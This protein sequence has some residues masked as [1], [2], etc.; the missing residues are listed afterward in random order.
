MPNQLMKT[1]NQLSTL[2]LRL[3]LGIVFFPHGAQKVLGWW[4]GSGFSKTLEAFTG[5]GMPAPVAILVIVAEFLGALGLIVGFLSR[6]AAAG[7]GMVMLGAIFLV[8]ARHGF[9]MNWF[10][11]QPGE[12]FEYHIL[13]LGLALAVAI[14]GSGLCSVDRWLTER[15]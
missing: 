3:T 4:G 14:K 7:I 2:I 9:F 1:D 11:T 5:M 6:V 13:A 12:G 8:H 15:R 10:G